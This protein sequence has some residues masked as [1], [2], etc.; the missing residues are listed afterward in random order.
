MQL[1]SGFNKLLAL[2]LLVG[3]AS[4]I[5]SPAEA[6]IFDW[7]LNLIGNQPTRVPEPA[8]LALFATGVASVA[9]LRRRRKHD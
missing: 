1:G 9:F 7:W 3:V 6:G 8:T 5:S 2:T 4:G